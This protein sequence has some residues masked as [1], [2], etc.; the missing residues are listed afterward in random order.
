MDPVHLA[1]HLNGALQY[2]SGI[3]FEK[4]C[5]NKVVNYRESWYTY[6]NLVDYRFVN[7]GEGKTENIQIA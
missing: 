7:R 6:Q 4:H 1:L 2:L 5:S 3:F